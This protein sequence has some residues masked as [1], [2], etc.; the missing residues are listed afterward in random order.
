[1]YVRN[2]QF[3]ALCY[4]VGLWNLMQWCTAAYSLQKQCLRTVLLSTKTILS[5][6]ATM[7]VSDHIMYIYTYEYLQLAKTVS[8]HIMYMYNYLQL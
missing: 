5:S 6:T 4:N 1:M 7:T 2:A 8:G 3:L